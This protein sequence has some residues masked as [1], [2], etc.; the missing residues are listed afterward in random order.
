MWVKKIEALF[1]FFQM[2]MNVTET[3]VHMESV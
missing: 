1:V 3:H 2:M